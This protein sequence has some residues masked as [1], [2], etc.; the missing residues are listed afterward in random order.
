ME[1]WVV[2][3]DPV[4]V[5][6]ALGAAEV[7]EE[8]L[9]EAWVAATVTGSAPTRHAGTT[10]SHGEYSATGAQHRAMVQVGLVDLIMGHQECEAACGAGPVEAVVEIVV[11]V[12][13]VAPWVDE[14][15]EVPWAVEVHLWVAAEVALD[16][17][18]EALAEVD[19][20]V[21][22]LGE[23]EVTEEQGRTKKCPVKCV[24]LHW[25]HLL[26]H[27]VC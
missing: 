6:V 20:C 24:P 13:A 12:E 21:V 16:Q 2:V 4:V 9:M 23:T 1:A 14:V 7:V 3:E 17:D 25:L 8:A 22:D 26:L 5:E 19:L 15:V 27:S 18:V 11:V 10:T